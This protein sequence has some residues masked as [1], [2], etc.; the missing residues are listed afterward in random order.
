MSQD[1]DVV[2]IGGGPGGYVAAIR[3]SQLGFKVLVIEKESMGGVC[4]NWGCIPTK[5]LLESSHF[6]EKIA[7]SH[8]FGIEVQ[9]YKVDFKKVISRSRKIAENMSKGVN[10]LMKKNNIKVHYG[11]ASFQDKN[12]ILINGETK[13]QSKYFILATGA[14][15]RPFPH[16]PFS[17]SVWSSRE[18]MIQEKIP[19]SMAIIGAGAIGVEF[20]DIYRT[21]GTEIHLIEMDSNILPL[22]D[23]EISSFVE[24]SYSKRGI[25]IYTASIV[26][27]AKEKSDGVEILI[28][29]QKESFLKVEKTLISIGV[30]PNTDS[31]NLEEIGVFLKKG[32]V[33]TNSYCQTKV[34]HIFAIGDCKGAPL[35]AHVASME[36]VKS[37]EAISILEKNPHS[38]EYNPL[39]YEKI[40]A[41]TY[42]NPE[43]AS[44]GLT[45]KKAIESGYKLKIGKFPWKASGRA[46]ASGNTNGLIKVISDE[47]TDEVLGIHIVGMGATEIISEASFA[48]NFEVT[49]HDIIQTIH[50][51]P[52]LAEGIMEAS[53]D[54]LGEALNV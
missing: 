7:K 37:A 33:E 35:L 4:L 31:M 21:M 13:I 20:A 53:A 28:K 47:K 11:F 32:F 26:E 42:C 10:F 3:A 48:I 49:T 40:P 41:C 29:S 38:L 30:I 2:V 14:K 46:N 43:V 34:D 15:P 6:L 44:V 9:N 25:K 50:A 52:T 51:H 22:E 18:A 16:L 19:K 23:E 27:K 36:G 17:P 45:E 39:N 54:C 5:A 1:Y 12:T 8:N 24:K